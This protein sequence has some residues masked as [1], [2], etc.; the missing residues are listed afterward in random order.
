VRVEPGFSL[1]QR[2]LVRP[3]RVPG[4]GRWQRVGDQVQHSSGT[5][6]WAFATCFMIMDSF[7]RYSVETIHD[8]GRVRQRALLGGEGGAEAAGAP[9]WGAVEGSQG[10]G[11]AAFAP[12]QAGGQDGAALVIARITV[13]PTTIDRSVRRI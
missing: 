1:G 10:V 11:E 4:A 9:A 6:R 12:G 5:R 7:G 2:D 3:D 13:E 8:H